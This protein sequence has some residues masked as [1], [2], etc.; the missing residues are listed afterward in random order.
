MDRS[1]FFPKKPNLKERNVSV[2]KRLSSSAEVS[3]EAIFQGEGFYSSGSYL[4]HEGESSFENFTIC[5]R[6]MVYHFRGVYGTLV[7]Y[8]MA[9]GASAILIGLSLY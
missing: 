5:V 3:Q 1:V 9:D 2:K 6:V 8:S 4:L 7:S